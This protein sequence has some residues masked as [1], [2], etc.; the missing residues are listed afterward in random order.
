MS[1]HLQASTRRAALLDD[2]FIYNM[3]HFMIEG[4]AN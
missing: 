2:P 1:I 3:S 4:L